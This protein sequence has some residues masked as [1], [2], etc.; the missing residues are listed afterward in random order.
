MGPYEIKNGK[1]VNKKESTGV[2]PNKGKLD[3]II[4]P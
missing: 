4:Y 3:F 1:N 2:T